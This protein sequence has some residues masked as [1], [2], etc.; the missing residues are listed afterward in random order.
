MEKK[1]LID[2]SVSYYDSEYKDFVEQML[3]LQQIVEEIEEVSPR[4]LDNFLLW[5]HSKNEDNKKLVR[6]Y[7]KL[8]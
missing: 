2:D 4:E 5:V 7:D 1:K 3:S 6:I 8:C